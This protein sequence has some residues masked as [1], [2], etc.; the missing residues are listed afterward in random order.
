[1]PFPYCRIGFIGVGAMGKYMVQNLAKKTTPE[2]EIFLHDIN[3]KAVDSLCDEFPGK[4][5]GCSSASEV[6][7]KAVSELQCTIKPPRN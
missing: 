2:T 6:A 1:M 7:N 3:Q 4:L 5:T